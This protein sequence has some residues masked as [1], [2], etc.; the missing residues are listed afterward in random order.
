MV[1]DLTSE[2]KKIAHRINAISKALLH[3]KNEIY[4]RK[5]F[6]IRRPYIDD[7]I[8]SLNKLSISFGGN[9]RNPHF[10]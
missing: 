7:R 9:F 6:K 5:Y 4:H 10:Y 8:Q 3:G 1:G 2:C